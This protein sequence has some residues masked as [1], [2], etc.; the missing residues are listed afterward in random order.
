MVWKSL[1]ACSL[2]VLV[3]LGLLFLLAEGRFV[4][5]IAVRVAPV[6]A[7]AREQA[8]WERFTHKVPVGFGQRCLAIGGPAA[9]LL[10]QAAAG[11]E[12]LAVVDSLDA[13]RES[14][15]RAG[16]LPGFKRQAIGALIA[17]FKHPLP[18]ESESFDL[19]VAVA[20]GARP[21]LPALARLV[22]PGGRLVVE[23]DAAREERGEPWRDPA[24]QTRWQ[25][26]DGRELLVAIRV[27]GDLG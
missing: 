16:R 14:L 25:R 7:A 22:R 3:A 2:V 27:E 8:R 12:V 1:A 6:M 18:F 4:E 13:A 20:G 24:F 21:P 19:V 17:N 26:L 15:G 11:A 23:G 5:Q 10:A 9:L